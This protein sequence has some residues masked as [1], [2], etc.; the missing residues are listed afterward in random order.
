[1]SSMLLLVIYTVGFCTNALQI[2]NWSIYDI[3][4]MR[5]VQRWLM[6]KF[7]YRG[8]CRNDYHFLLAETGEDIFRYGTTHVPVSVDDR[9]LVNYRG[10]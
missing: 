5:C 4:Y 6:M 1:M 8:N 9:V 3:W 2:S 10:Q 7:D